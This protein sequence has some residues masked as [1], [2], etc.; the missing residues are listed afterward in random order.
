MCGAIRF[1]PFNGPAQSLFEFYLG[2]EPEGLS[3]SLCV[4]HPSGQAV[5]LCG[6]PS[7][8][9][10]E[11]NDAADEFDELLDSDFTS[12]ANV[13]WFGTVVLLC[14]ENDGA[15]CI[16]D[17][18]EFAASASGTPYVDGGVAGIAGMHEL[19][20]KRWDHVA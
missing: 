14:G 4:E 11:A 10:G 6:I 17:E 12:S 19:A 18:E 8:F 20:D 7:D 3:G 15:C 1:P 13:D 16:L 2:F 9:A 5:R